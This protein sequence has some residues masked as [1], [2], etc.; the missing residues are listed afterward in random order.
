MDYSVPERAPVEAKIIQAETSTSSSV[1]T[2]GAQVDADDDDDDDDDVCDDLVSLRRL[3]RLHILKQQDLSHDVSRVSTV[4]PSGTM[5]TSQQRLE[6][7]DIAGP[8][9]D[10]RQ[11][12]HTHAHTHT[13]THTPARARA[14]RMRK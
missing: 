11:C 8:M 10:R 9:I 12:R 14:T 6:R 4:L 7:V 2:G 3:A 1:Q 13:H 5:H